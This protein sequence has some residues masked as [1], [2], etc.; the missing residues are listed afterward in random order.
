LRPQ[1]DR[2]APTCVITVLWSRD[3]APR[4]VSTFI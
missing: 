4:A 3:A 1:V 2:M